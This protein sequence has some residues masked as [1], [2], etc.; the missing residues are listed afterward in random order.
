VV[1]HTS[2]GPI[3]TQPAPV[4]LKALQRQLKTLV[5]DLR[6]QSTAV[7]EL[8]SW[9]ESQYK[10][11][12][13]HRTGATFE[14]WREEQLDQAAVAWLLGT[15]FVRF[16][17]DNNLISGVWLAGPGGRTE[18][19]VQAQTAYFM[20]EP[21]HNDRHWILAS[22]SHMK[23][24]SATAGIFDEHNPLWRFPIS[25][26]AAGI[27][28]DFWR[29]GAGV[30][31]FVDD[32]LDTR[33]LGDLYQDLSEYARKRFALL[34]TPEFVEEFILDLT[35]KP[36]LAEYG[37]EET[38][39]IDPTCGSGHFLLGAFAR[40][41][42]LWKD[43]E[44]GTDP[45]V[46]VQKALD[47]VTGVDVNPFAVSIAKFRLLV[48]A[49]QACG[50]QSLESAPG[51]K[52]RLAAGDSLLLWDQG[53]SAHQGDLVALAEGREEFA[54][55]TED[56]ALLADYLRPGQYTVAVGNPPYITVKDKVLNERYRQDYKT[57]SGKYALS[58][59]FVER[60]FELVRQRDESGR[61]G[62]VGQITSNSFMKRE[63][64]KKLIEEFFGGR[65]ELSHVI[66]TSGAYIPGHGT[67]TVILAGRRCSPKRK[68]VRAILGILGEPGVPAD[69]SKGLVWTAIVENYDRSGEPNS[70]VT[71]SDLPRPV[72][73][74][75][76]WSLSGGGAGELKLHIDSNAK[77]RLSHR[78]QGQIGFASFPGLDEGFLM[79]PHQAHRLG[80][81]PPLGRLVV[82]G[83]VVRDWG[84]WCKEVGLTPYDSEQRPMAL[85]ENAAW[86]RYLWRLRT[87]SEGTIGF[88]QQT[89]KESGDGW[90]TW[91]R[92][93]GD[94]YR[95]PLSITF[96]FVATHNHFVLDR[97]GKVFNRSA[98]VI[99][100]PE[101]ASEDE[102][103]ALLGLLNSSTAC[104]WLKQVSHGKGNGG[105]NE[106]FRGAEWEE[107]FEFTGTKLQEFP[108]PAGA[109]LGWARLLNRFAQELAT[110]RPHAMAATGVPTHDVLDSAHADHDRIRC[111]M[112]A[113]QEELDWEVYRLYS[114]L[115]EDLTAPKNAVPGIRFGERAFEIVLA[116]RVARGETETQWFAR[117][118]STP[119]T[120]IPDHWPEAYKAAVER[121]I[122]IIEERPDVALI[123]RP[124]CKRRWA[125]T[126]WE[127]QEKEA[128]RDWLLDGLEAESLW[129][130]G[131]R[132]RVLS[133]AQLADRIGVDTD[134]R[135]VLSL[136]CGRDDYDI[137]AELTK[138][139][140]DET[141]PYLAAYRY[142]A[143]GLRKRE[144]WERTWD[145]QR[146]EDAGEKL[147]DPI[148][149][150]PKYT[151]A[152]FAK[153]SYWRNRGKLDVPKE[154]FIV[155]P[156]AGRDADKTP[157]IG[158]A[159]WNHLD[160]AQA[161][162]TL[163][164]GR[165]TEDGWPAERLLP[166]IAGLVELEPWLHQWYSDPTP[167]YPGNPAAFY[168]TLIDT[169]LAGLGYGRADLSPEKLP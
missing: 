145:L 139:V 20:K 121:R 138:L 47:Q 164:I 80:L 17:E 33:F 78:I 165:K 68:T 46:R 114:L 60:F 5:D 112:V 84:D 62:F 74:R 102:H 131:G 26:D 97:G 14:E 103:L 116:R 135:S 106:G 2:E 43:K 82:I 6:E 144:Q 110:K 23:D 88:G 129:R 94:R 160:Q 75:Y 42:K 90:W 169:E 49:L 25:G 130:E 56:A 4:P 100:L 67:P 1:Q 166:L 159:G 59:P 137:A 151:S 13:G 142:K 157:V 119:I 79:P 147:K 71:V 16:C 19:A 134:F 140:V 22:F 38:S 58:V 101:G 65:V 3:V 11:A 10:A 96:A 168:T 69:P 92:W 77:G 27:L 37:L 21:A 156:K 126:P 61:A 81:A 107:F 41:H 152:D 128:L 118:G 50:E 83:E 7:P 150:P 127:T 12:I 70:Y 34:Q 76:P 24:L 55:F 155:Y 31:S 36:S 57:C 125:S 66:D 146:R 64:G 161:L 44:P 163:Y 111:E 167:G 148:R 154:R 93:V 30:H 141:V 29:R 105:V 15:V 136:Y 9:L 51:F 91:Y 63:F 162:A 133:V 39:V 99:K 98:P 89:R 35:L 52:L 40:L 143:S 53:S 32:R 108:V 109:P 153:V 115:D 73:A 158:W 87:V 95:T 132:A 104:F 86:A 113:I 124:E 122:W 8:R 18:A 54:Y 72:L 85:D 149:V 123:E 117:H 28:L 45:R 120:E 48:A